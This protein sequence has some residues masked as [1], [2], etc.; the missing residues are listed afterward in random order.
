MATIHH[1]TLPRRPLTGTRRW[2]TEAHRGLAAGMIGALLA[3]WT[4]VE[5]KPVHEQLN[6]DPQGSIEIVDVAGSVALSG[7]DRPEIEVTGTA[8]DQVDRVEV[9]TSGSR[10]T[11]RVIPHSGAGHGSGNEA[12]LTVHVPTKSAVTVTLV[13]ADLTLGSLQGSV[14]L[15]TVSG[16]VTGAVG[17]DFRAATV[18][19]SVHVTAAAARVIEVK[20]VSGTIHVSGSGGEVEI[21]T[22]SGDATLDL[23]S[24]TRGRFKSVSGDLTAGF[25]LVAEGRFEGES[26]SGDLKLKFAATPAADFDVQSVSGDITNCFGPKP[27]EAQ[28]GPGSRLAFKSGEG[29]AHVQIET[30]SGNVNLCTRDSQSKRSAAAATAF[31]CGRSPAFYQVDAP[32]HGDRLR[33]FPLI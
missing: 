30:K 24:I 5:A 26:V 16:D 17:G 31:G 22:I 29:N 32:V 1:S 3:P 8:G 11:V 15:Q 21:T 23:E 27:K 14:K 4:V 12:R 28:Y 25:A 19:G 9:T 7:W 2:L 18:S 13:S 6:V 20:T 10:S 33:R